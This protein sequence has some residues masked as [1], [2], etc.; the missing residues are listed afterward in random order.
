MQITPQSID[1]L[2][3]KAPKDE[4]GFV[5]K[6][7]SDA[8]KRIEEIYIA[9]AFKQSKEGQALIKTVLEAIK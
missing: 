4:N 3:A 9:V 6:K 1:E 2:L 8:K 7:F 5:Y